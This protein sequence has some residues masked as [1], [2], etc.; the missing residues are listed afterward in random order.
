M[1]SAVRLIELGL[2]Q[3][4]CSVLIS[5]WMD[6]AVSSYLGGSPTV[7][8][9]YLVGGNASVPWMASKF[10]GSIPANS[11]EVNPLYCSPICIRGINP[12]LILVGAAEFALYDSK[13]W[14]EVLQVAGIQHKLVIEWG[15]LHIYA[16]GSAW[17]DPAVRAKTENTIVTWIKQWVGRNPGYSGQTIEN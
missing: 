2:P 16:M 15:Q 13:K 17:V 9:D 11:H 12:Q 8:S 5:P 1:L 7:E 3:P 10:V 6:M 4:A 14:A